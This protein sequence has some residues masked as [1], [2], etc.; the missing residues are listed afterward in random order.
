[1]DDVKDYMEENIESM[2]D[3]RSKFEKGSKEQV[4]HD[5]N[6]IGMFNAYNDR[7]KLELD[8]LNA[9]KQRTHDEKKYKAEIEQKDRE[10]KKKTMADW[11]KTVAGGL[12]TA[13][14][15]VLACLARKDEREGFIT[16]NQT[17]IFDRFR[18][19]KP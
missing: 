1:M 5:K 11:G 9:E 19:M 4:E 8:E 12:A 13:A 16:D 10:V 15:V 7:L 17:N 14:G 18:K 3:E 6:I 2:V